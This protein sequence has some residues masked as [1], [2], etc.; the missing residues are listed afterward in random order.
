ML[1]VVVVTNFDTEILQ[2]KLIR[3]LG[4]R[5]LKP[6]KYSVKG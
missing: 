6:A 2:W 4:P 1:Y 3:F 5:R